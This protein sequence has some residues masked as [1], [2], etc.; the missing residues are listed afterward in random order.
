MRMNPLGWELTGVTMLH[1][2]Y[3][4]Y[5]YTFEA[6]TSC[7]GKAIQ[8]VLKTIHSSAATRTHKEKG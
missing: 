5:T 4:S 6:W 7:D 1:F 2:C 8:N 3:L